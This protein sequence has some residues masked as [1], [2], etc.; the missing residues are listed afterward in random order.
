MTVPRRGKIAGRPARAGGTTPYST[1]TVEARAESFSNDCASTRS[2]V[3]IREVVILAVAARWTIS[4]NG[5]DEPEALKEGVPADVVDDQQTS[6][7]H[8][9]PRR[10]NYAAIIGSGGSNVAHENHVRT[11]RAGE[12][13]FELTKLVEGHARR[14]QRRDRGAAH[15]VRHAIAG[16]RELL[17]AD[18]AGQMR[19]NRRQMIRCMICSFSVISF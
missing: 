12:E 18:S 5:R 10:Y 6:Q 4:S 8:A 15:G 2:P 16:G 7:E 11:L 14:R 19:E 9:R 17:A 3:N 1:K 13:L